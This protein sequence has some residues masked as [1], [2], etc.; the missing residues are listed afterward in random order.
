MIT[1]LHSVPTIVF[2]K[3]V[4]CNTHPVFVKGVSLST[5]RVRKLHQSCSCWCWVLLSFFPKV[6]NCDY[7]NQ[8]HDLRDSLAPHFLH[9]HTILV[10]QCEVVKVGLRNVICGGS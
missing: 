10:T 7:S 8:N 5:S 9:I 1:F 3:L 4:P 2:P 6:H